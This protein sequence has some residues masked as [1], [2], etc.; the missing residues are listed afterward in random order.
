MAHLVTLLTPPTRPNRQRPEN[1][2]GQGGAG[3]SFYKANPNDD[4]QMVLC[5]SKDEFV[6]QQDVCVMCGSFGQDMEGRVIACA[7]CG[8]A[9]HPYCITIKVRRR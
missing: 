4:N 8:Q 9:Y 5:S 2:A 1:P 6:L 7:Q 3:G